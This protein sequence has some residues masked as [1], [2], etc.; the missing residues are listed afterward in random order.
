MAVKNPQTFF[1]VWTKRKDLM[2]AWLKE[3]KKPRNCNLI[4]SNPNV[5]FN[6]DVPQGFDKV[7][8]VQSKPNRY[9]NC[10]GKCIDCLTCYM[11]PGAK[12]IF[13]VIK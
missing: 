9:T 12:K 10:V 1:G 3:N 7:F 8:N 5:D 2:W 13:E 4:W 11:R 6:A